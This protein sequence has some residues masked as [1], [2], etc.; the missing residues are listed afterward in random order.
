MR[1]SG[2]IETYEDLT[3]QLVSIGNE[4]RNSETRKGPNDMDIDA[5]DRAW[6]G[7]EQ[8]KQWATRPTPMRS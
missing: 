3:T 7:D 4:G 6:A 1:S 2:A 8:Q 5:A